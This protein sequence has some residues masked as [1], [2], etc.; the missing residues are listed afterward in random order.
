MME[1]WNAGLKEGDSRVLFNGIAHHSTI[2]LFHHFF[3][4]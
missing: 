3:S 2:P 1:Q 4:G